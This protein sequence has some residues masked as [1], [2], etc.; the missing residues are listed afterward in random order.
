MRFEA[1]LGL[2]LR[3]ALIALFGAI[4]SVPAY[5]AGPGLPGAG[6]LLRQAEPVVPP[7]APSNNTGLNVEQSGNAALPASPSFLVRHIQIVG[8]TSI[9]TATLHALVADAE[10]RDLT[11]P[12]VGDLA[13]RITHYYQT[14]GYPLARAI[15][16]P[17]TI[18]A[19]TLRIDVI[20]ARYGT[21][22]LVNDS[23]VSDSLLHAM[24]G[25]LQGG[26]LVTQEELDRSLLVL[27]DTPG[28]AVNATLRPGAEVGTSDLVVGA[29]STPMFTGDLNV[30]NGGDRYSGRVRLGATASVI[31]PLHLGDIL[32]V[33]GLSAGRD[34]NYGAVSY[35]A[36]V[37]GE[38][39]RAGASY[40]ALRYRLGDTLS[41]IGANGNAQV[42]STWAK[43]PFVR[44]RQFDLYGQVEYDHLQLRDDVTASGISTDRHLDNATA[45]LSGD[46]RDGLLAGAVTT[47]SAGWT[48][49]HVGFDNGVAEAADA[50]GPDTQGG[51]SKW[52]LA[53]ARLQGLGEN[54]ALYVA[55]TGQ[56]TSANLD[57]SQQMIAGGPNSVRAYDVNA[58]TGD[59]GYLLTAEL[60]HSFAHKWFGRWQAIAFV[61]GA[62]VTVNR[63]TF[64]TGPNSANLGGAGVGL[65]WAGPSQLSASVLVAAPVGGRPELIGSTA[66][67]R[68]W[69]KLGKAF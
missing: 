27:S 58:V 51:F 13:A 11:L 41:P 24:L 31:N 64:G 36:L 21:V 33:S 48:Y 62:H 5:A 8:N 3:P 44:S 1:D 45:S 65:N 22:S 2:A 25:G 49:G 9:A 12:I 60:R 56:W 46:I 6:T 39:T 17:Q 37:D 69:L 32:S 10:D 30:D 38:G 59:S 47:W 54:D 29:Q 28:V 55:V 4:A 66:S 14:H 20:E 42:V 63:H 18:D 61:D 23:R 19:G 52:N 7:Q 43:H 53:V 57:P 34:M 15:V 35:E 50:I 26:M 16:P 67:V 68:G 40:S